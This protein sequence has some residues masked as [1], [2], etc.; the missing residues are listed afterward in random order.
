MG[1]VSGV[2]DVLDRAEWH[3]STLKELADIVHTIRR[4]AGLDIPRTTDLV[5]RLGWD[6]NAL[7]ELVNKTHTREEGGP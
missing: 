2:A 6:L 3:L 7:R 4:R 5:D 1:S